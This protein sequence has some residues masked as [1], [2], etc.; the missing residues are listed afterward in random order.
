[1]IKSTR[2]VLLGSLVA[3]ALLGTLLARS[4]QNP[5]TRTADEA[6]LREYAG[7]YQWAPNAFLYLQLWP[8]LTGTNQL[9]A[10]DENGEVRA[11]YLTQRDRFSAGPGAGVATPVESRIEFQRDASG[12]ITSLAWNRG[13]A[14]PRIAR[15]VNT[16]T[17]EE[18][19]F[20]N[21]DVQLA[22]TLI[23]PLGP[24]PHPAVILVH[25]SGAEDRDY[26]LP[27]ARF[28]I[29][30]GI[31]VLGYDKRGVGGSTGDWNKASFDVLA[32]DVV[33]AFRVPQDSPRHSTRSDRAA[34]MEPSG[35]GD[36]NR[37]H[38]SQGPGISHQYRWRRC[39]CC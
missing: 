2:V 3:M 30:H 34:R 32:G 15:R 31:A 7:V 11:L 38:A 27:F 37:R 36:A 18:V 39:V 12:T 14:P 13:S 25:A 23:K 19:R 24:G 29:R 6:S 21:A 16:E 4:L 5:T 35:L 9:V 1:M 33:A 20:S 8:E 26:L 10:F 28:L 17:S 22:G